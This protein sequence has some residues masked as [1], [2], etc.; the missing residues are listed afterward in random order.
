MAR[1]Y[2]IPQSTPALI[3]GGLTPGQAALYE[4]LVQQGSLNVRRA[5]FIAGIPRTL[6]YKNLEELEKLGLVIKNEIPKKVATF[7]AVHPLKLK[8]LAEKKLE[9]AKEAKSALEGSLARLVSD[10]NRVSGLPGAQVLD[11][12]ATVQTLLTTRLSQKK[13]LVA[14]IIEDSAT[15][16]EISIVFE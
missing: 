9:D 2:V 4:T 10:F 11:D 1:N 5:S 7:S 16:L 13:P 8:E 3:Q 6:A 12:V 15:K 14:T